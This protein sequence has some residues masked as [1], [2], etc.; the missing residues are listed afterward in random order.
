MAREGETK[1]ERKAR[2]AEKKVRLL[3][4]HSQ[5]DNRLVRL[6]RLP[7]PRTSM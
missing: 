6:L 3:L 2:K 4:V 1:E 7:R 5:A